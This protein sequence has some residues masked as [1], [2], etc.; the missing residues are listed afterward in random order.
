MIYLKFTKLIDLV[1]KIKTEYLQFQ[2][3]KRNSLENQLRDKSLR[4]KLLKKKIR[5][6]Y[7]RNFENEERELNIFIFKDFQEQLP[8]SI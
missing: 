4:I 8:K 2:E 1:K 7:K 5:Q 6:S 3:A